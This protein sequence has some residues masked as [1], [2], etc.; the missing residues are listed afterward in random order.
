[1]ILKRGN[2]FENVTA[3]MALVATGNNCIKK[4]GSLVMGAGS[5]LEL[6]QF[7]PTLPLVF[8][9]ILSTSTT[10]NY[11]VMMTCL[12]NTKLQLPLYYGL[13]ATKG[14][15]AKPSNLE[16]VLF[17]ID[18]FYQH[19]TRYYKGLTFRLAFPA[20]RNGGLVH[21]KGEILSALQKLPDCVEVW[22]R[23]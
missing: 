16:S 23:Y 22:E 12:Y 13:L 1:M 8:G 19:I 15:W 7:E 20:I 3:N 18:Q 14:H 9:H 21:K 4:D 11:S 5:A 17:N 2:M 6:A 10:D